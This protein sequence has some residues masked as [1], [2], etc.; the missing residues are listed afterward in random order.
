MCNIFPALL[1]NICSRERCDV[2]QFINSYSDVY[3][4][5]YCLVRQ[6]IHR[7]IKIESRYKSWK[8]YVNSRRV[9]DNGKKSNL[10]WLFFWCC[11]WWIPYDFIRDS[12]YIN[13]MFQGNSPR[14]SSK[15]IKVKLAWDIIKRGRFR[16]DFCRDCLSIIGSN[17]VCFY[18]RAT[19]WRR[20]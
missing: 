5:N 1:C 8:S 7:K 14:H 12:F 16:I 6:L 9:L 17:L 4:L 11:S 20:T 2:G 10:H 19:S 18:I 15:H 3:F 13:Y